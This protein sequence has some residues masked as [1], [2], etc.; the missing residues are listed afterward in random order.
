MVYWL[1]YKSCENEQKSYVNYLGVYLDEYLNWDHQIKHV[2]VKIN[3]NY[4]IINKLRYYVDWKMLKQLYFTLIY[5]YFNYGIMSWGNTYASKLTKICTKQNKC[6]RSIFFARSRENASIYY[7][8]DNILK[9]RI[10]TLS[11]IIAHI[12]AQWLPVSILII[13]V[14]SRSP[15]LRSLERNARLWDNPLPEARNPG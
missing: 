11:Y 7:K 8:L 13:H 5:S 12:I 14:Q 4:G 3:K 15:S 10:A 6:I 9:L 1:F 2:N